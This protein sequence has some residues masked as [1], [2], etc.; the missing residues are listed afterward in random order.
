MGL[1]EVQGE[2]VLAWSSGDFEIVP[3]IIRLSAND[4]HSDVL[5]T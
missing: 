5:S 2:G 1:L 3:E 4:Q